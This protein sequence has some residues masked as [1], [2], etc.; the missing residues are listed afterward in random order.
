MRFPICQVCL[1]NNIL[2]NACSE[3]VKK[4]GIRPEEVKM[5]RILNRIL[6]DKSLKNVE[7]KRVIGRNTLF[8]ITRKE[9]VS[10]LIGRNGR[11]A[12][13]L[14][15][16]LNKSIRII[17]Q[18]STFKDFVDEIFFS[19]P[20]LGVNVL[21]TSNGEKYRIRIP[22]SER[23][24]LPISSDTFASVSKSLFNVNVDVVFE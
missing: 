18:P 7:I 6:K 10:K 19:V 24:R 12:K 23:L 1:K 13:K 15:K 11:I 22:K 3:K 16:E 14:S 8:I 9:D 5:Y 17:G 4:E 20:L 2:C 21:Y